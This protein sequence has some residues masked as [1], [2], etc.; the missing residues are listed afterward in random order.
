[1]LLVGIVGVG[2]IFLILYK[3]IW[4]SFSITCKKC[5]KRIWSSCNICPHCHDNPRAEYKLT[6]KLC[7]MGKDFLKS[8]EGT[9]AIF[10][11]IRYFRKK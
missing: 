6:T 10:D 2:I 1:M 5:G 11:V 9:K 3:M 7:Q 8:P 4:L